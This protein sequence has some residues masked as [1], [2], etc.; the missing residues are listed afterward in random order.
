MTRAQEWAVEAARQKVRADEAVA[1]LRR[2]RETMEDFKGGC[3]PQGQ[4]ITDSEG[5]SDPGP[6][7]KCEACLV[8]EIDAHL[9]GTEK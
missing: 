5:T 9:E 7:E 4:T 8:A 6:C 1:L 3:I 2:A